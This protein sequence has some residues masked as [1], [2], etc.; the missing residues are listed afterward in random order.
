MKPQTTKE[1]I[2]DNGFLRRLHYEHPSGETRDNFNLHNS[3]LWIPD[4]L[5]KARMQFILNYICDSDMFRENYG[6]KY[7]YFSKQFNAWSAYLVEQVMSGVFDEIIEK[8]V[9]K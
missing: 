7:Y 4:V 3:T 8:E 6:D 9:K 5:N 2:S 1:I